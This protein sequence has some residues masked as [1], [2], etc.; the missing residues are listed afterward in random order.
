MLS[1]NIIRPTKSPWNAPI[2][3][4]K[5][6][7]G[8]NRFVCDYRN[9]NEVTKKDTYPLPHMKDVL[10]KMHSASYWTTLDAASAYWAVPVNEEHKEKTAFSV[11]RGKFEFNVMPYG[12]C[13]AG[14]TYQRL[15]DMCLSGLSPDR[16][17]AYMDDVV[18]LHPP[19]R[20]I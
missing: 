8:E 10:D 15:M 16:I 13:N 14:P 19:L 3:M 2:L 20:S 9:L 12:L 6:K 1:N 11:K 18:I 4:V 7:N 5:K 17:L